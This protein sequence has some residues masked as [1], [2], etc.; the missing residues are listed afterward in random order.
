MP[1]NT[2]SISF[3]YFCKITNGYDRYTFIGLT[4]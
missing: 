1:Q 4:M 3:Y 2:C